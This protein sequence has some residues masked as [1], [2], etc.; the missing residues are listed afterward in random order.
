ML[1][2]RFPWIEEEAAPLAM[3]RSASIF[4]LVLMCGCVSYH[5]RPISVE[6]SATDFDARGFEDAGLRAFLATNH[7]P[8]EWPRKEWDLEALT[9]AAFYYQ[10][11]LDVAR[12]RWSAAHAAVV[13]A[14][15]RPNP[16][17]SL[18]PTYD[19]SSTPPWILGL[20]F[21]IPIE[22]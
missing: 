9:L 1:L 3:K 12:A 4:L 17:V 14:G 2:R 15:E 11:D 21:D 20:S 16:S 7:E 8:T 5:P 18:T 22:T 6:K 13:T 10:P 19:T